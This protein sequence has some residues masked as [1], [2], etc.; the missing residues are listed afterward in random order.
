MEKITSI[1]SASGHLLDQYDRTGVIQITPQQLVTVLGQIGTAIKTLRDNIIKRKEEVV[2]IPLPPKKQPKVE[3]KRRTFTES[4]K[5][6]T[7]KLV[8]QEIQDFEVFKE[9]EITCEADE[10]AIHIH[11]K[12]FLDTLSISIK[13]GYP[14]IPPE[15]LSSS[16][17]LNPVML[18]SVTGILEA[19]LEAKSTALK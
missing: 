19:I 17:D 10:E 8:L 16:L 1:G 9:A 4:S 13:P 6:L 18:F 5:Q 7:E 11:L 2:E 12:I 15:I 3:S 14:A